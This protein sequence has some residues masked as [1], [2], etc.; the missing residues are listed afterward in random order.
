MLK[1][2]GELHI[3]DWGRPANALMRAVFLVVQILDGFETTQDSVEDRLTPL[4]EA[5]GFRN[6]AR[7]RSFNTPLGTIGLYRAAK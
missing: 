4:I 5:A 6:V 7:T 2:D 3:A 1:P